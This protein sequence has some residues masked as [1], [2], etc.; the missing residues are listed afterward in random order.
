MDGPVRVDD[1]W[2]RLIHS[3]DR[4]TC[5]WPLS[6]GRRL[7]SKGSIRLPGIIRNVNL[8]ERVRLALRTRVVVPATFE[9]CA[10]AFLAATYS[11]LSPVEGGHDH[12][13]D[14]DIY[15]EDPDS[16]KIGRVLV[17]TG[18]PAVNLRNGLKRMAEEGAPIGYV[19]IACMRPLSATKRAT[20]EEICS[21]N[22]LPIPHIYAQD[23]FAERLVADPAWREELLGVP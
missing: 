12:G 11:R 18:D 15:P 6:A 1:P 16:T 3:A 14:A 17:T 19:V 21:H 22:G 9:R 5:T 10:C 13:R 8:V 4:R 7:P 2:H 23:W 20:L